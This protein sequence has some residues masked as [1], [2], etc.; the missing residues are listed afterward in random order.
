MSASLIALI[1][2]QT[3]QRGNDINIDNANPPS[4]R[5]GLRNLSDDPAVASRPVAA[6]KASAHPECFTAQEPG[7]ENI[8]PDDG[9]SRQCA[10]QQHADVDA[11]NDSR[12]R[13]AIVQ[14]HAEGGDGGRSS[15]G[16]LDEIGTL[17]PEL[18]TIAEGSSNEVSRLDS[19]VAQKSLDSIHAQGAGDGE[20]GR[21]ILEGEGEAVCALSEEPGQRHQGRPSPK[22]SPALSPLSRS[23]REKVAKAMERSSGGVPGQDGDAEAEREPP[24]TDDE[25]GGACRR[26]SKEEEEQALAASVSDFVASGGGDE[27]NM[28]A[29]FWQAGGAGAAGCED[30]D[31]RHESVEHRKSGEGGR[32]RRTRSPV[33]YKELPINTKCRQG[34]QS[35]LNAL[36]PSCRAREGAC[37]QRV[38]FGCRRAR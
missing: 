21:L 31:D 32:S 23:V 11:P 30:R 37:T 18:N 35:R 6:S 1:V 19:S 4:K 38:V 12:P 26:H 17:Y 9:S 20:N 7:D 16:G 34:G 25:A 8:A 28:E 15:S 14:D 5:R 29:L 33:C 22:T 3:S 10:T 27:Q 36:P 2:L 13:E 24:T